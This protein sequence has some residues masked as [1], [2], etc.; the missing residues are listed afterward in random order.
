MGVLVHG[1][2][3]TDGRDWRGGQKVDYKCA[4]GSLP[5][6]LGLNTAQDFSGIPFLRADPEL[7]SFYAK[8]LQS[9]GDK[10]KIGIAWQGGVQK[11]AVHLRSIPLAE[12]LPV[13]G[14]DAT[15]V[16][17]QYTDSAVQELLAFSA[18]TGISI[19]HWVEAAKG[20]GMEEQAALISELDLVITV[21]Q[22]AYHV[23]GGLGIPC[24]VLTPKKC[25]WREGITGNMPWY[26]SVD[27][28]RQ[29][30]DPWAHVL[31]RT[32][33]LLK[34]VLRATDRKLQTG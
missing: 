8:R 10:P 16:S 23:A 2:H 26:E 21:C 1:T 3:E 31:N 18:A 25:S 13:L 14:Q 15:F 34:Q 20:E 17:L 19:H 30:D 22:T 6:I 28:I 9:L 7:T 5:K 12:W 33:D 29:N 11:T 24:W 27:L 32:A 4:L